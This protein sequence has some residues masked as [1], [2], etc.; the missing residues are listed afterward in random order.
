M[1]LWKNL[2]C[3]CN[4][5]A[6][7]ICSGDFIK[8][9]LQDCV[10][11]KKAFQFVNNKPILISSLTCDTICNPQ[12]TASNIKR[13]KGWQ[14]RLISKLQIR[15]DTS[16]LNCIKF[17]EKLDQQADPNVLVIGSGEKGSGTDAL[18]NDKRV[19]IIGVDIYE[20]PTVDILCDAHYLPFADKYFDGVWIQAVLEHV[21]DPN[22]VV[23][24]ISRVLKLDGLVYSEIPFMQ[25]IHEGPYDFSR[26]TLGGHRF[27][28]REYAEVG[29]GK[30]GGP[31]DDMAWTI[32]HFV[33]AMTSS[34]V[35]GKLF[36]LSFRFLFS[37]V[38]RFLSRKRKDSYSG[39]Y[40]LGRRSQN[41]N[42]SHVE[43]LKY[44][45]KDND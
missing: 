40:F 10:H 33:I 21:V 1:N 20:S 35:I 30:L 39:S 17:I 41:H 6:D 11:Y 27:L 7:L 28:F 38:T 14:K 12:N 13:G 24:E 18:W 34:K 37:P 26:F 23:S 16:H 29:S 9:G 43:L 44:Y 31:V 36:E 45:E 15:D 8:C 42:I 4:R 32:K 3:P 19:T 5:K 2:K 22:S 25:Q